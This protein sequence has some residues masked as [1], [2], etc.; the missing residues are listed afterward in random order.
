M[1]AF[2]AAT[3]SR[4]KPKAPTSR[5]CSL[6]GRSRPCAPGGTPPGWT[7]QMTGRGVEYLCVD[8]ARANIRA[9]EGKLPEEYWE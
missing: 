3:R 1:L 6:C 5:V 9:I 8:C 7:M 2:V 4:S